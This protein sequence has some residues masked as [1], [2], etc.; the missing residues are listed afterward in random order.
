MRFKHYQKPGF[1][2]VDLSVFLDIFFPNLS[3]EFKEELP[4]QMR[5]HMLQTFSLTE[6]VYYKTS[7][8]SVS[9]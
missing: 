2:S 7:C 9:R 5:T 1:E 6:N 8:F 3:H 4:A